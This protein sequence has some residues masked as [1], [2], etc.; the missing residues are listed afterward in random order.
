MRDDRHRLEQIAETGDRLM[1]TVQ[2]RGITREIVMDDGDIQW[3]LTTPLIHIGEQANR[4]S[5]AITDRYPDTPWPE[6][7]GLRHRL[8]HDYEDTNWTII[9]SVVFDQLP[10][11][12]ESVKSILE[13]L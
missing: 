1:Q 3:M 2:D 11:F 5:D 6:I 12:I 9:C 8:V 13:N 10:L 7:A 4:L